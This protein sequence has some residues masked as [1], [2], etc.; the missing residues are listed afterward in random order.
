MTWQLLNYL[1]IGNGL[2]LRIWGHKIGKKEKRTACVFCIIANLVLITGLVST[3][4]KYV[5]F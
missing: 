2:S 1:L 5:F 3:G 4:V